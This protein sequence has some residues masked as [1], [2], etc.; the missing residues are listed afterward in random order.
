MCRS[1]FGPRTE[2]G[3][4]IA[5]TPLHRRAELRGSTCLI[6]V[7]TLRRV[8]IYPLACSCPIRSTHQCQENH[9]VSVLLFPTVDGH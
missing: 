1:E 7:R 8:T 6:E 5:V 3:C 2:Y 4:R 9:Y